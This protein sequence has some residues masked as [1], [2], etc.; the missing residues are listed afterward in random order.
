MGARSAAPVLNL[1][2]ANLG[3]RGSARG[4]MQDVSTVGKF[5]NSLARRLRQFHEN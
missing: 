5:H 4:Q 3:Q 1:A 2:A